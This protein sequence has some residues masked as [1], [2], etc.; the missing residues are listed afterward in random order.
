MMRATGKARPTA[1]TGGGIVLFPP[2][3]STADEV[4]ALL[5]KFVEPMPHGQIAQPQEFWDRN[6]VRTGNAG[7]TLFAMLLAE[8]FLLPPFCRD[9]SLLLG[10]TEGAIRLRQVCGQLKITCSCG[11]NGQGA[12]ALCQQ[13]PVGQLEG[14]KGG[15]VVH[16]CG[17]G[18]LQATAF[19]G[20]GDRYH[21]EAVF[22]G[23]T[24]QG[25]ALGIQP[26]QVQAC[27]LYT[28]PSP[29]DIS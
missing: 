13:E 7:L 23:P 5:R 19:V 15:A 9:Q 26:M 25:Q 29:R 20:R 21:T 17:A 16:Q 14:C 8:P 18:C 12:D 28:S 6:F 11:T 4:V 27:L 1:F 24:G 22:Q 3:A 2:V 10:L